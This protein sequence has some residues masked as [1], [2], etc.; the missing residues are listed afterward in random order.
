MKTSLHAHQVI[1]TSWMLGREL[2]DDGPR[3]GILADEMGM[4]KT[5]QTLACIVSNQASKDDLDKCCPTTLVVAP[6]TAIKQW[7]SEIKRHV[8]LKSH[9]QGI[10]HYKKSKEVPLQALQNTAIILVSYHELCKELP[11]KKFIAQLE[12]KC[13]NSP[14]VDYDEKYDERLGMLFKVNFWR[15]VLDESQNIKNHHSQTSTACQ[16]LNGRYRWALS[17]TPIT[18]SIEEVYPYLKFLRAEIPND[19]K[20]FRVQ[21][22]NAEDESSMGRLRSI[23]GPLMLRRTMK[24]TFLGRPLYEIPKPHPDVKTVALIQEERIIYDTVEGRFREIINDMLQRGD[25]VDLTI[26]L[27]LFLRLRQC[28]AHPF[29]LE[30]TMKYVLTKHNLRDIKDRIEKMGFDLGKQLNLALASQEDDVCRICYQEPVEPQV[31]QCN[32]LFCGECLKDHVK[33]EYKNG[34]IVPKCFECRQPLVDYEPIMPS[35]VEDPGSEGRDILKK[36]PK[37]PKS[38][39]MFLSQCDRA[40]PEPVVSSA[41][42]TAVKAIILE[43]QSQA[44][45]DK[46]IVFMEFKVTGAVLGR[47]LEA[48]GIP[49]L[50]FFGDM[51]SSSKEQAIKAFHE[52]KEVKVLIASMRCGSVALNLTVANR[53]ILV[54]LWWNIAMEM[55]AFGRV[56]RIGQ[57]KETHFR[58]IVADCTI[59]DRLVALQER[60]EENISKIMESGG[61][62]NLSLEETLSLF[63]RVSKSEN[64]IFQ[65]LPDAEEECNLDDS[66]GEEDEEEEDDEDDEDYEPDEARDT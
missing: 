64:G 41:K 30:S 21:F 61:K 28:V 8:D 34:R 58:R 29:L 38:Q 54:D 17:G 65:V 35:E 11:N 23:M 31:P 44:P 9:T 19:M 37:L 36:H 43:W 20:A 57:T 2:G 7:K 55:Q 62:Q 16:R 10:L 3:G 50:Y 18:N 53:V 63:G 45:D 27:K 48:E 4:G 6:A 33:A 51:N 52:K 49:F 42:T 14:G 24:D 26:Y 5:L 22:L 39:S 59:D 25:N 60:K 47:M 15:I 46:I 32:H 13:R 40:H 1:G 66:G 56:F 12:E